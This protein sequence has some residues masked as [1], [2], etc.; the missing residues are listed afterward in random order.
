MGLSFVRI[1]LNLISIAIIVI[2]SVTVRDIIIESIRTAFFEGSQG[3]GTIG[4][5]ISIS[6]I[7]SLTTSFLGSSNNL[8][9]GD[10]SRLN[11]INNIVSI[12][13]IISSQCNSNFL[14]VIF[15]QGVHGGLS[16]FPV[17]PTLFVSISLQF[18]HNLIHGHFFGGITNSIRVSIASF[19]FDQIGSFVSSCA[20]C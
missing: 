20:S 13:I 14:L 12:S 3:I 4:V 1:S 16:D 15:V 7:I 18:I 2:P 6:V 10:C 5:I 9:L 8:V 11:T 19:L 17:T